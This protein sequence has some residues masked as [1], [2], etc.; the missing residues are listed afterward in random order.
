MA[1]AR[2]PRAAGGDGSPRQ[3]LSKEAINALPLR[4]Y[5]GPVHFVT[6]EDQVHRAVEVLRRETILGFD[7]ETKPTFR[8]GEHHPPALLQLAGGEQVF[9]FRLSTL[10]FEDGLRALLSSPDIIKAGVA[11][12][13]DISEL[14]AVTRFDGAGVVDVAEIARKAGIEAGGLRSL[15]AAVLGWRISKRYQTSNWG[16]RHLH[17]AQVRYAATDAW[18][19]REIY[20]ALT[21]G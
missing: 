3:R 5:E 12:Q 1:D 19:S 6:R 13:R 4:Q 7:T 11:P 18:V 9:V 20:L 14:Q 17:P 8:S 2:A 10:R 16:R 21:R 15:A